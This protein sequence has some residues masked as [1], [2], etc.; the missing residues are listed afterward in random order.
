MDQLPESPMEEKIIPMEENPV[1]SADHQI[2]IENVTED[3]NE[4]SQDETEL[5]KRE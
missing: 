3:F 4:V 5:K 1:L 2:E